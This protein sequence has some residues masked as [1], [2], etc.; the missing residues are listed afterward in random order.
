MDDE[1]REPRHYRG[2]G[3]IECMDAMR[4]MMADAPVPAYAAFWWGAAFKYVWRWPWKNGR[5][6]LEKARRCIEYLLEV[7]PE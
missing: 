5:R 7:V 3:S 1:V 4:S 2:D 6:D